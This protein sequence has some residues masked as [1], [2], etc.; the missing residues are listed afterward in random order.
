MRSLLAALVVGLLAP[1]A[2]AQIIPQLSFGVAG[3][4]NFA[5]LS[6]VA[7]ADLDNTTGFHAG[8]YVDFSALMLAVRTGAFYLRAGEVQQTGQAEPTSADFLTIP[9]EVHVTTPT[10]VVRGYALLGPEFRFPIGE[11]GTLVDTRSVNVAAN[12]GAG[13]K[14]KMPV[15]G[16]SGFGEVRY[17]LDLTGF[18][19]NTVLTTDNTYKLNLFMVRVGVGL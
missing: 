7:G 5:S 3:G 4:A 15:T 12:I 14:F 8:V 18:A 17:A 13:A 1:A 9:V 19:E 6:D 10:P 16:F 11:S 2:H